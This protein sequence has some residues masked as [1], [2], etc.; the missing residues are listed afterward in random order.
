MLES[1]VSDQILNSWKEIAH[2]LNRGVRTVQR[3]ES[4][5]ALPVR[6]PRGKRRS[7]VIAMRWEIDKWLIRCPQDAI[8][9]DVK[10]PDPARSMNSPDERSMRAV[11]KPGFANLISNSRALREDIDRSR[12]ELQDVVVRVVD[13]IQAYHLL[14]SKSPQKSPELRWLES[15]RGAD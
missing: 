8:E 11:R 1:T 6:R 14:L 15:P 5:L 2:Y 13:T 9:H 4:E 7:A 10:E 3:W 12:R